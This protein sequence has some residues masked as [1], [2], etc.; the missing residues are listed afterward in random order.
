M[1]R[2]FKLEEEVL[3]AMLNEWFNDNIEKFNHSINPKF[4]N[5]N[6]V[7]KVLKTN[8]KKLN[9]FKH[10]ARGR[11]IKGEFTKLKELDF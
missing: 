3:A 8:M 2:L 11:H 6:P 5:R 7:A 9:K 10:H 1:K 4:W